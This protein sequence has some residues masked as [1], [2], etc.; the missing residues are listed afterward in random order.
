[1]LQSRLRLHPQALWL[2]LVNGIFTLSVALSNTFV[3]IYL[4][5]VDRSYSSIVW[6]NLLIYLTIPVAFIFSGWFAKRRDAV[7]TLRIGITLHAVFYGLSLI[8]GTKIATLPAVIGAVMGTA[9]GF[10]WLSFNMLSFKDS[11]SGGRE[12]FY[13]LNGVIGAMA[14]MAAPFLAG[15]IISAEDRFG[16]LSGYHIIFTLSLALF[17]FAAL[18]SFRLRDQETSGPLFLGKAFQAW[19]V[20]PWRMVLLGCFAYG[21]RE[22]V[23]LFLIGL[24]M[25]IATGSEL[26]LGEFVLLQSG[27][28]TISFFAVSRFVKPRR[29]LWVLGVGALS[30]L[31]AALLFLFPINA[32]LIL[33][34]GSAIA[35]ALPLFLIPFQG[36][37]FDGVS[38]LD[39]TNTIYMEHIIVREVFENAGRVV[40]I[41]A[42]LGLVSLAPSTANIARFAVALG[43]VQVITWILLWRGNSV[44]FGF[45][46][47][48]LPS[49][50]SR[51]AEFEDL[52]TVPIRKR[53]RDY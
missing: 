37:V 15:Y 52:A 49:H 36:V 32:R 7:F 51:Y 26:K 2:L 47:K 8:G 39:K 43:F 42:F 45:K 30:M 28:S 10:Y 5:K 27:L 48:A 34:Y 14:G 50:P 29:R 21:M 9:A 11:Q 12:R 33:I 18:I 20:R 22:G 40:G 44:P 53:V 41:V 4:W 13:G 25:Y 17:L 24:L 23:F 46:N 35:L 19:R 3:N 38:A 6:Y 16:G 31:A 1:M